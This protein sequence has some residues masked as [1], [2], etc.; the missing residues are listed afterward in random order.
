MP[1]LA[2]THS[3]PYM[4]SA[5]P[6]LA[7]PVQGAAPHRIS[8][9]SA[10]S[11]PGA[12]TTPMSYSSA[13][14]HACLFVRVPDKI[15]S[16]SRMQQGSMNEWMNQRAPVTL[17]LPLIQFPNHVVVGAWMIG[18]NHLCE[19]KIPNTASCALSSWTWLQELITVRIST[20]SSNLHSCPGRLAFWWCPCSGWGNRGSEMS[21]YLPRVTACEVRAGTAPEPEAASLCFCFWL[22]LTTGLLSSF[23]LDWNVWSSDRQRGGSSCFQG[24]KVDYRS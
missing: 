21:S 18:H 11:L 17:C 13:H 5:A 3:S 19:K 23:Y 1:S 6:H 20:V 9:P 14:H 7:V 8:S 24:Q 12:L 2:L 16:S 10:G 4:E 22:T 15:V